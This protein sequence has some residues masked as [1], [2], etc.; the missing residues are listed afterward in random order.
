MSI[1]QLYVDKASQWRWR[2]KTNDQ[3][4]VGAS[5]MGFDSKEECILY[6]EEVLKYAKIAD[7]EESD[8]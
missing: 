7:I 5:G 2:L 8:E 6:V 3:E 4:I 1:L